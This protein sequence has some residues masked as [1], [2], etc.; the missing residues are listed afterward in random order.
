M[1]TNACKILIVYLMF[2]LN[3]LAC[4]HRGKDRPDA[5]VVNKNANSD[6]SIAVIGDSV[7]TGVFAST[8]VGQMPSADKGIK[9]MEFLKASAGSG[10]DSDKTTA[11]SQDFSSE[12]ENAALTTNEDWG[13]RKAI[14]MQNQ[15][16]SAGETKLFFA[17]QFGATVLKQGKTLND[18]L[19]EKYAKESNNKPAGTVLF[20][21]G[22][23]DYCRGTELGTYTNA[24]KSVMGEVRQL[25]PDAN[26]VVALVPPLSQS[27]S[28]DHV[29]NAEVSCTSI[30]KLYC[31]TLFGDQ[32][33]LWQEYNKAMK[34]FISERQAAGEKVKLAEDVAATPF[35]NSL[36]SFD[37]F[38]PNV[39]GQKKIAAAFVKAVNQ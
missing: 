10:F 21:M 25:H 39:A 4:G 34:Q 36:Q 3:V 35:N 6:S 37:C 9:L 18:S 32:K 27:A 19:R 33:E 31:P 13:V 8:S 20:M 2:V 14:A 23:N 7:S 24:F 1:K 26:L 28:E 12:P 16:K 15:L 22:G 30:R 17:G 5:N 29:Y 38:H 11:F